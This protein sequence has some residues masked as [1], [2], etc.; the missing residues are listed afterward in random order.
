MRLEASDAAVCTVLDDVLDD[1]DDE[2]F[3]VAR[4]SKCL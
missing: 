4:G 1:D 2:P 3:I